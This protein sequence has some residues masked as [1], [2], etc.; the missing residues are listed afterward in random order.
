LKQKLQRSRKITLEDFLFVIA[1]PLIRRKRVT[2]GLILEKT[3]RDFRAKY[4]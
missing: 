4:S 1:V 3:R 2:A